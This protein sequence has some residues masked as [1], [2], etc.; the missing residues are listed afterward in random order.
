M[1][2]NYKYDQLKRTVLLHVNARKSLKE[3]FTTSSTRTW[4]VFKVVSFILRIIL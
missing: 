4:P 1:L 3:S 2:D